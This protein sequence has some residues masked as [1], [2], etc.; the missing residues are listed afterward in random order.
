MMSDLISRQAAI[1]AVC[2]HG[3]ELDRR[4]I[5]GLAVANY[6]QATVDL[7]EQL[8]SAEPERNRGQWEEIEVISEAYD[9]AGIK[10]WAS[11]MKCN[12]C[13]FTTYA[14][15]GYFAQYNFCPNCG[16]DMREEHDSN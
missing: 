2:K 16:A 15:E 5:T 6:K 1:E 11:L 3:A 7:L 14:I 12:Q 13:G 10:T 8:P 9:I 4:G